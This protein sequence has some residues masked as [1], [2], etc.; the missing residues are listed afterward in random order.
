[1]RHFKSLIIFVAFLFLGLASA[2]SQIYDPVKWTVKLSKIQNGKATITY[3]ANIEK[4][5]HI[6]ST[7]QLENGPVPTSFSFTETDGVK[8]ISDI[9]PRTKLIE[10][11]EPSFAMTLGWYEDVATFQQ[12]VK[13]DNPSNFTLKGYISYMCCSNETCTPPTNSE[14]DLS[15]H[16]TESNAKEDSNAEV[17]SFSSK[18]K[19][20]FNPVSI[21][22]VSSTSDSSTTQKV[23]S[24]NVVDRIDTWANVEDKMSEYG[25]AATHT[26]D[27]LLK[28]LL[29]GLVGGF[30]A[31]VTPCVWPII[32]MT[33]SFFMKRG[34]DPK[35][36]RKSA[37]LYGLSI[38][39]IYVI[40]GI[41]IT[42]I[43]GASG[44]NE[45]STNAFFNVFLFFLLVLFS[46]SFFGGFEIALPASWST[47][48]DNKVDKT[49][50]YISILLM[51]FTLVIVSFSCTGPIIGTLLV[52][53]AKSNVLAPAVGMFGFSVALAIPFT[54]FAFFP[55]L[56]KNLPRSGGWLNSVKVLLGFFELAFALKFL[57]MADLTNHWRILDREV[58]IVLW[59]VIFAM[60]GLYLIGK[61]HFSGDDEVEHVSVP[62]LFLSIAS[63][64]FAL[65]LVPGLWGAP[66]KAASAFI[67]PISTQDFSLYKGKI[68]AKF[69][70]YDEAL[71]Y[72]AANNKPVVVDFTGHACVNC[73]EM[74]SSVW[75]DP[76]VR[77]ILKE[78]YVLVSLFVDDRKA[79][80]EPMKVEE[81]GKE[82]TLYTVGDKWTY[83]EMSK[84]GTNAQPFYVLLD[85][86]GNPLNTSFA[87]SKNSTEEFLDFLKVGLKNFKKEKN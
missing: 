25:E 79:L 49:S 39:G 81:N 73:R 8:V 15:R 17:Q 10:E 43:Y 37:I 78:D 54:L 44:L 62:R 13:I 34:S 83:L 11:Y 20:L 36:G 26:G 82:K 29:L 74:E 77:S 14:F 47:K 24:E 72:A 19:L 76:R 75:T 56:L 5:W 33:V 84:F 50:G 63:F 85:S 48:L 68:S 41:V 28:V 16:S 2:F 71:K 35:K 31:V 51:A 42:A 40:L 1:M 21:K 7:K 9:N 27:S 57:S 66:L 70:D 3:Q 60:A 69:K 38:I 6:Y 86:D 80:D 4:G 18:D 45:L 23:S 22:P 59:V 52:D 30:I 65:Y 12:Q 61:I 46:A 55:S 64:S 53:V 67:P 87:Y 58:F 32:P